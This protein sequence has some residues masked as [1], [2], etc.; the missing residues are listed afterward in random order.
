[1]NNKQLRILIV[2][3]QEIFRI[4]LKETLSAFPDIT[5]VGDVPNGDDVLSQVKLTM[6][7]I[8]LMD[9]IEASLEMKQS[10]IPSKIIILS[11]VSTGDAIFSAVKSGI[12]GYLVK[13]TSPSEL[14]ESIYKVHGGL[15]TFA[16]SIAVEVLSL[17]ASSSSTVTEKLPSLTRREIDILQLVAKGKGNNIIAQEL[18]VSGATVRTHLNNIFTKLHLSN[19][20]QA[21]LYALRNGFATLA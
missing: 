7:D 16:P 18:N 1:M 15:P 8:I 4:G 5:I 10:D 11:N 2:D 14:V 20:V 17:I 9:D 12:M 6:P 13:N 21:T 19:R 3:N